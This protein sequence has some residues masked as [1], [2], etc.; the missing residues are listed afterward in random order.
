[1]LAWF[2]N[3]FVGQTGFMPHGACYLWL[4]SILWLHVISDMLIVLAYYSIPFA[5]LYFVNKRTDIVYRWIFLLFGTFIFLCGTTHLMSIWT[6]WYPD[7]WL[8]GLLK[9]ITAIVSIVT[10]LLIWPLIPKLL[11]LPSPAALKVSEA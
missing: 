3:Y 11:Q 10:A 4:P 6:I 2:N 9:L 7:Y 8:F 5:L 1:M